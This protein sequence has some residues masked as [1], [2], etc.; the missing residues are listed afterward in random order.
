M[1]LSRD[2]A[3]FLLDNKLQLD[4]TVID[5]VAIGRLLARHTVEIIPMNRNDTF[6]Q[7]VAQVPSVFG[8]DCFHYRVKAD[9]GSQMQDIAAFSS[10]FLFWYG[11]LTNL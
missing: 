3:K 5:D 6:T 2:V 11:P 4:F 10:L 8:C 9:S 7:S 1:V